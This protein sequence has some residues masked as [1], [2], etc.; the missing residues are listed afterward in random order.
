MTNTIHEPNPQIEDGVF[1]CR[2]PHDPALHVPV[3]TL[4]AWLSDA[5][6]RT[7]YATCTG[8]SVNTEDCWTELAV[9]TRLA[10]EVTASRWA[11]VAQLLRANAIRDWHQ[12]G[13]ALN[14][15]APEAAV[16]FAN[17]LT[18]QTHLY[19]QIGIG[20]PVPLEKSSL[21]VKP[22]VDLH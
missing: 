3:G 10:Q 11:T 19:S 4:V 13:T 2:N 17:W 15:T 6:H 5:L 14:L 22:H 1:H 21:H 9:G 8:Q 12:V 7:V 20:V 18:G 16:G